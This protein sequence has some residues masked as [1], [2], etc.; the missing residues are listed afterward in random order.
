MPTTK[1]FSVQM[2]DQPGTLGKIC[3][4][5]ADRKVNI[6]AFQSI[7]IEG[8]SQVRLVVDN[9]TTAKSVL[10]SQKLKYTEAQV[11]QVKLP[12]RPGELARAATK[13]GE[14]KVNINYA[15]TG[16]EAGSNEPLLIFGVADAGRAAKILDEAAAAAAKA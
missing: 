13:L 5:L 6:L 2:E 11:A 9:P 1:E 10:D 8:K 7:P 15:Y 4:T 3:R 12:H 14:A 16:V